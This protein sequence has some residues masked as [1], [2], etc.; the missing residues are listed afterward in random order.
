MN[1]IKLTNLS[2][3][4]ANIAILKKDGIYYQSGT[5]LF[6]RHKSDYFA[7]TAKHC[8]LHGSTQVEKTLPTLE[9]THEEIQFLSAINFAGKV[10]LLHRQKLHN[11]GQLLFKVFNTDESHAID[12]AAIK[13][14]NPSI[15]VK[16]ISISSDL[17]D[18]SANIRYQASL[19]ITGFPSYYEDLED[20]IITNYESKEVQDLLESDNKYYFLMPSKKELK[21]T[22]IGGFSGSAILDLDEGKIIGFVVGENKQTN[23]IYGIYA[24]YMVDCMND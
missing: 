6:I 3:L 23:H 13:L 21:I 19:S 1:S 14:I 12:V 10:N 7:V 20:N 2:G 9:N 22:S 4:V 15:N 5:A 24:K 18:D 17:I 16:E 8:L 11:D